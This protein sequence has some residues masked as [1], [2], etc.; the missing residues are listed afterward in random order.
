MTNIRLFGS[1]GCINCLEAIK[2]IKNANLDIQYVDALNPNEKVQ[3]FCDEY[4]VDELPHIQ[5]IED[6]SIVYEHI[7]EVNESLENLIK[8]FQMKDKI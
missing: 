1:S 8:F 3:N 7:G 4:N 2:M 6:D 5:F